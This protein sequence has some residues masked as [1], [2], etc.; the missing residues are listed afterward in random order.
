MWA[1]S[2]STE[3]DGDL[4]TTDQRAMPCGWALAQ[5][6]SHS[7]PSGA[8]HMCPPSGHRGWSRTVADRRERWSAVLESVLGATPREFESRILRHADLQEHRWVAAN[9]WA[10]SVPVGSF[11]GSFPQLRIVSLPISAGAVVPGQRHHRRP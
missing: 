2:Y 10:H 1:D 4:P 8:V 3:L 5:F 9:Q 11:E 6:V 7:P